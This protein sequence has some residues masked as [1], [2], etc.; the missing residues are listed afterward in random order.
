MYYKIISNQ[1]N[2]VFSSSDCLFFSLY[3]LMPIIC[4]SCKFC[5]RTKSIFALPSQRL[6]LMV[7]LCLVGSCW[8]TAEDI[9]VPDMALLIVPKQ[10]TWSGVGIINIPPPPPLPGPVRPLLRKVSWDIADCGPYLLIFANTHC[11]REYEGYNIYTE[12]SLLWPSI[13]LTIL[14]IYSPGACIT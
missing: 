6:T 4:C 9:Y 5:V 10:D 8:L 2:L 12:V 14:A 3:S 1:N 11:E 13:S 7:N